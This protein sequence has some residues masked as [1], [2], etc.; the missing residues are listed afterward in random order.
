MFDKKVYRDSVLQ[1]YRANTAWQSSVA[2]AL[3]ALSDTSDRNAQIQAL[4]KADAAV[5]FA[6]TPTISSAE[7][8]KHIK[9]L[10][11]FLNKSR[12]PVV[13]TISQLL[14]ATK[15]GSSHFGVWGV[16]LAWGRGLPDD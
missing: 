12:I 11:M 2:D 15:T 13:L 3:R 7:L 14:K 6:L 16:V 4:A 5:L 1:P 9:S 10:E 8:T